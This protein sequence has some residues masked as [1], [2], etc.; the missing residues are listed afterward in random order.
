MSRIVLFIVCVVGSFSFFSSAQAAQYN[1]ELRKEI[2]SGKNRIHAIV[3]LDTQDEKVNAIEGV[4]AYP[5][6]VLSV[7]HINTGSSIIS[8]WTEAPSDAQN[9]GISFSAILQGGMTVNNGVLFEVVFTPDEQGSGVVSIIDGRVL[10]HD[11]LGTELPLQVNGQSISLPM[12]GKPMYLSDIVDNM[13]PAEFSVIPAQEETLYEG[14]WFVSF[15]TVDKQSGIDHYEYQE[16]NSKQV[17]DS[18][19]Q[20]VTSPVVLQDQSRTSYV[21]VKAIDVFGNEEIAVLQPFQKRFLTPVELILGLVLVLS[22]I[23]YI[24][25]WKKCKK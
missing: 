4:L 1:V 9:G 20:K 18:K 14:K 11:G 21:F 6:N 7:E 3:S 19:W 16:T 23:L 17:V 2:I 24:L 13:P 25:I 15:S 10:K 8:L 12:G 22:G 5:S